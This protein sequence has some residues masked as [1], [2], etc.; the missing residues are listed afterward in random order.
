MASLLISSRVQHHV[1]VRSSLGK[2][3]ILCPYPYPYP[4]PYPFPNLSR[5][6]DR[7]RVR[8]RVRENTGCELLELGAWS[9]SRKHH[10]SIPVFRLT[11]KARRVRVPPLFSASRLFDFKRG[12]PLHTLSIAQARSPVRL[13]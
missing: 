12:H 2:L 13:P 11:S 7:E 3:L 1:G 9:P 8:V 5:E 6:N 4:Y 10:A